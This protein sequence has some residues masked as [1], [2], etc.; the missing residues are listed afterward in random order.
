MSGT[1]I[2]RWL[3][4]AL[5]QV[6]NSL[7]PLSKKRARGKEEEAKEEM[8]EEGPPPSVALDFDALLAAQQVNGAG[9]LE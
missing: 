9:S 3:P 8:Q 7:Q 6:S 5:L 1:D 4:N 2:A